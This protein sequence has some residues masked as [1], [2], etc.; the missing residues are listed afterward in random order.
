[1]LSDHCDVTGG[2]SAGTGFGVNAG[3]NYQVAT[4]LTGT[5]SNGLS[6]LQTATTKAA[7]SYSIS[8]NKISVAVAA[9]PGR[10]TFTA[11]HATPKDLGAV[12]GSDMATAVT[13][14]IYDLAVKIS[15]RSS[16]TE[17]TSFGVATADGGIQDWSLG[18]QLVNSGTDLSC[19]GEL[20][21]RRTRLRLTTI[22]SLQHCPGQAG[23]E[24]T[25]RIH[26][27][28]AGAESGSAYSSKYEVFVNGTLV[29]SSGAGDF[30]F[31]NSA[32]RLI[33]FD[34]APSAGPV[35]YDDF[36]LTAVTTYERA[37]AGNES[38]STVS[39]TPVTQGPIRDRVGK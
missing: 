5:A 22:T 33:L 20:I 25:L 15:N 30:R 26:V 37:A 24:I 32:A 2:S 35:T 16:G 34:T 14:K 31:A 39:F 9:N 19:I 10:F 4:R 38:G 11:D 17:R 12:L 27:T 8:S 36:S 6:Y 7:S 29:F 23:A 3:V 18:M 21:P 28:D 1:M 13:P